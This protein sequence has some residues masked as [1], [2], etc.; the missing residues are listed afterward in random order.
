MPYKLPLK[1][2]PVLLLIPVKSWKKGYTNS[3]ATGLRS[4]IWQNKLI[5]GFLLSLSFKQLVLALRTIS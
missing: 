5:H 1:L 3:D 2:K 4:D